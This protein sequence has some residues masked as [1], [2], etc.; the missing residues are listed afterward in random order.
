M[1]ACDES[2]KSHE[3][4]EDQYRRITCMWSLGETVCL[5]IFR[6]VITLSILV[7]REKGP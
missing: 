7:R 5:G 2:A 6:N 4:A 1:L 3:R